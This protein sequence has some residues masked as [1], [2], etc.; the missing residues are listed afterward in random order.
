MLYE[1]NH[2]Q[3]SLIIGPKTSSPNV[4]KALTS[5]EDTL[6]YK[7]DGILPKAILRAMI[8]DI[9]ILIKVQVVAQLHNNLLKIK[10]L[11]T[12]NI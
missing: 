6:F 11:P 3:N 10:F 4:I 5:S 7:H 2:S 8:Q 1:Y 12:K 9:L